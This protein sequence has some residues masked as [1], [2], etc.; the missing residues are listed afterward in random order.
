[1]AKHE[2]KNKLRDI[3]LWI[4]IGKMANFYFNKN[5]SWLYDKI[6]EKDCEFTP[7]EVQQLKGSLVDLAVR[8]SKCADTL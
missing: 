5:S 8:I 7:E 3:L 6:D 4:N 1:M 2:V